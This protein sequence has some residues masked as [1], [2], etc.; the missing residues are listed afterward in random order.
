ME[1]WQEALKLVKLVYDAIKASESFRKDFRLL[2]QIQGAA[3]SPPALLNV[4][5]IQLG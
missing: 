1:V 2:N 3:F 4:K 5:S